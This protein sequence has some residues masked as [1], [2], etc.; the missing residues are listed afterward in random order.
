MSAVAMLYANDIHDLSDA[1]A[2]GIAKGL[3]FFASKIEQ[4]VSAI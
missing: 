4:M 1:V 2:R 3:T